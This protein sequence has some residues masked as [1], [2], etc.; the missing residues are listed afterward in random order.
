MDHQLL[1]LRL[2]Y[3]INIFLYLVPGFKLVILCSCALRFNQYIWTTCSQ[4]EYSENL[5]KCTLGT[6]LGA[7]FNQVQLQIHYFI[8]YNSRYFISLDTLLHL[9][10]QLQVDYITIVYEFLG[11]KLGYSDNISHWLKISVRSRN[12]CSSRLHLLG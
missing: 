2:K 9:Q 10:I 6:I 12:F 4:T 5:I 11:G 3:V 7:L 1:S 8:R